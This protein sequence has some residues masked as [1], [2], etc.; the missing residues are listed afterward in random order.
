MWQDERHQKIKSHLKAFGRLS[1][2]QFADEAKVSRETVRR[3]LELAG[4]LRRVRGG[5]VP[6]SKED[7]DYKVR[8]M[9]RLNEKRAIAQAALPLLSDGMTIFIDAGTT[10]TVMAEVLS[11]HFGLSDVVFLTNS[12]EVAQLLS[13]GDGKSQ[14]HY[15]VHL[16]SGD[17]KQQPLETW[18]AAT[19]NDISR[20]RADIALLA[21]WG[22]DATN[23]AMNY[24][25]HG[26]EIARAMVRNSTQTVIL[27][28]HSKVGAPARSVFCRPEQI[29]HLVVDK[30][31]TELSAF[32]ELAS[33]VNNIIVAAE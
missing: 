3:E 19:I 11:T 2:D 5:A 21:P 16:L 13:P 26:A 10:T 12:I 23:G 32:K 4:T 7:T 6:L 20:F 27:S 30:A 31:A 8:V 25:I 24:F 28:D 29:S 18:G 17:V 22:I 9:Q 14:H 15:R 33:L 1:I